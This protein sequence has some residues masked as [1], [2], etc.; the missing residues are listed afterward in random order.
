MANKKLDKKAILLQVITAL[1]DDNNEVI[2]ETVEAEPSLTKYGVNWH[3]DV[4]QSKNH[5]PLSRKM[6]DVKWQNADHAKN[7][8]IGKDITIE[9]L[10]GVSKFAIKINGKRVEFG[11]G[12]KESD[13]YD[14]GDVRGLW[15]AARH[16]Y[17]DEKSDYLSILYGYARTKEIKDAVKENNKSGQ[18]KDKYE[19]AIEKLKSLGIKPDRLQEYIA[20]KQNENY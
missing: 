16:K 8:K 12:D 15:N 14:I 5:V 7:V 11:I 17:V 4:G 2:V 18:K 19:K 6:R 10:E 9:R 20:K 3:Y 13:S 1:K